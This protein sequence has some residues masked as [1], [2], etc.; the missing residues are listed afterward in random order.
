[1]RRTLS[2]LALVLATLPAAAGR[3][4][5]ESPLARVEEAYADLVDARGAIGFIDSGFVATYGGKD[6]KAWEEI[7]KAKLKEMQE[8]LPAVPEEKLPARERR[9]LKL[10]QEA[11][12]AAAA[13]GAPALA[14]AGNCQDA[15][16]AGL[17]YKQLREALYACFDEVGNHLEFEGKRESRLSGFELLTTMPE[18]ERRKQMFLAYGPLWQAINAKNEPDS[19]YRR[20]IKLAAADAAQKKGSEIDAAAKTLGVTAAEVERWLEQILETWRQSTPAT[21]I[22]PWDYR[23]WAGEC[24][25]EL[26][27]TAPRGQMRDVSARFYRDLGASDALR[28]VIYDI[29]PRDG[30]APVAYT[31]YVRMGRMAG[32]KWQSTVV[33]I[34]ASYPRGGYG[35]LGELIHEEGHAVHFLA[36]RTSPAFMDLGDSLFVESFADVPA[37]SMVEPAWQKKYLGRSAPV[38]TCR[39][40]AY[41]GV[42]LDVAWSL[43]EARMLREPS[44]DPNEVWTEITSKYLHIVPHPEY[45]W[46]A[47]RVQLVHLPG[48]MVNYGLGSVLTADL[49]A[50][51]REQIG[52]FDTGNRRWYGWVSENLLKTGREQETADL[53]R[54]FLGR[55]VSPEALQKELARMREAK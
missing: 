3:R 45:A 49:R 15:Q 53:L 18:A 27:R 22:E 16:R 30:K 54:R 24:D 10:M 19:P 7:R 35:L 33:R 32:G 20:L 6:R 41:A 25:R 9:G 39:R 52:P 14:P 2:L 29:E 46:W 34:S 37:W 38:A 17:D 13:E 11:V 44:A 36:L 8:L 1:M 50:R 51:I 4:Q 42:M 23:Y 31:D 12:E 55:P 47:W 28:T 5:E 26:A 21:P 48:Y 40:G 43:F